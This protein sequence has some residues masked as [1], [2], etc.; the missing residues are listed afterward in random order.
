M[1]RN[2]SG[3]ALASAMAGGFMLTFFIVLVAITVLFV[4]LFWRVFTR[5]GYNGALGLLCLIPSV[6][7]IVCMIILA[8]GTWPNERVSVMAGSGPPLNPTG[9]NLL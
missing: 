5:A 9:S 4:W 2:A 7:V 8:F 3:T 1:D 6:G